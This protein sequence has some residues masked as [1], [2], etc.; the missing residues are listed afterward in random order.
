[1]AGA[2]ASLPLPFHSDFVALAQLVER[3]L[4]GL[5]T[6]AIRR[7]AFQS[8]NDLVKT[9]YDYVEHSN[10]NSRPFVWT[11]TADSI[12]AKVTRGKAMLETVH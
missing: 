10:E 5:T 12:I 8:V 2:K 3:W 4:G 9:I 1:M 6:K 11:A 7:G